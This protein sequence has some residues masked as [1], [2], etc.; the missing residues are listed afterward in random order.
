MKDKDLLIGNG[1][2]V[3]RTSRKERK[4]YQRDVKILNEGSIVQGSL[5]MSKKPKFNYCP[6]KK[7]RM[8]G[9]YNVICSDL[10]NEKRAV[11]YYDGKYLKLTLEIIESLELKKEKF[12]IEFHKEFNEYPI[13]K[14][15]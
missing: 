5:D 13:E 3:N 12:K 7:M 10:H 4:Q 2:R 15:V 8:Q 9:D 6:I 1:S 11:K 14:Y